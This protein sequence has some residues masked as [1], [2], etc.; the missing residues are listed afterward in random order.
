MV[1]AAVG[2]AVTVTVEVLV[3]VT[4]TS[5][6]SVE[7]VVGRFIVVAEE[8]TGLVGLEELLM[9]GGIKEELLPLS[10]TQLLTNIW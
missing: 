9:V 6:G 8:D 1:G 7:V 10:P 2:T 4:V 3:T 5:S